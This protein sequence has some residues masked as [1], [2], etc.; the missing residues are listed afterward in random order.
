MGIR[1]ELKVCQDE[2]KSYLEQNQYDTH[3]FSSKNMGSFISSTFESYKLIFAEPEILI[4]IFLQWV[5]ICLGY[6]AWIQIMYWIPDSV[7]NAIGQTSDKN[8][9]DTAFQ[10]INLVLIGWSVFIIVLASYPIAICNAAM[11]AAHNLRVCGESFALIKSLTIATRHIG[12]LWMFTL[13]D[14]LITCSAILGRLPSKRRWTAVDELI[15]YSWKIATVAIVP[16]LVNGRDFLGAGKDSIALFKAQPLRVI[17][18][19]LGYSGVCWIVGIL[20][21]IAAAFFVYKIGL[22][23]TKQSAFIYHFYLIM[24]LPLFITI[25]LITIVIRPFFLLGVAK[26]YS[27]VIDVKTET[28]LDIKQIPIFT[29]FLLSWKTLVFVFL[30]SQL[31]LVIFFGDR[32]GFVHWIHHLAQIDLARFYHQ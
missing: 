25:G 4:F 23:N 30:L 21:Y 3:V 5:T 2:V 13:I 16:A 14:N 29:D 8:T 22:F 28:E 1:T 6:L 9:S 31:L 19:R 26:I 15:Y 18:L 7:W 12:R 10:L 20:T 24:A 17:G 32:I 27:D 11:V